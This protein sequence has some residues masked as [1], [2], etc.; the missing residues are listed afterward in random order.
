MPRHHVP[1]WAILLFSAIAAACGFSGASQL[2]GP[3]AVRCA[4]ALDGNNAPLPAT[5][6]QATLQVSTAGD[7]AWT[8]ASNQS[9]LSVAPG[10]GQGDSTVSLAVAA[11]PGTASRI[12]VVS[13]NTMRWTLTQVGTAVSSSTPP[14]EPAPPNGTPPATPQ[15]P[16]SSPGPAPETPPTEPPVVTPPTSTPS[17]PGPSN[18]PGNDD[19]GQGNGNGQG[20]GGGNGNNGNGNGNNGNGNG[21]NG[22]GNGN[23]GNGNSGNG[24]S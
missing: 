17:N 6:T 20:N 19:Q 14:A 9:W 3:D 10:K 7:C 12:A 22:N 8:A 16:P 4:V 18:P 2:A 1:V 15:S 5:Q 21:N 13:V 23:G 11:N 24:K